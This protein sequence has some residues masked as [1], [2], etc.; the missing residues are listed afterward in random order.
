MKKL[1][2]TRI[3]IFL[4]VVGFLIAGFC[5]QALSSD[6]TVNLRIAST[7]VESTPQ[8]IA[9]QYL[10]KS[11][12]EKSNGRII[13]NLYMNSTLGTEV[14]VLDQV[15]LGVIEGCLAMGISTFSSIDSRM[16]VEELPFLF[17]SESE[18]R[19]AYNGEFGDALKEIISNYGFTTVCFFENG[20]RHITNNIRPIY[21][22]ADLA[23]IKIRV[24]GSAIRLATFKELGASPITMAI[25]EVFTGLQQ[26]TVDGQENPFTSIIG[27]QF[28]EVQKYL[29]LSSHIYN[30]AAI[31][32]NPNVWSAMSESDQKIFTEAALEAQK[33]CYDGCDEY[34]KNSLEKIKDAGMEV[35]QIETEKFIEAV[36]PIWKEYEEKNGSDLINLARKYSL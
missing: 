34:I 15:K 21:T 27:R 32:I 36:S 2:I 16:S 19:N 1:F 6:T 8:G 26:G 24:A 4:L 3:L 7:A 9:L 29:S 20:M 14:E 28:Q 18:A 23:G 35:N 11:V 5:S 25:G 10:K 22:P 30:T 33:V 31:F 13:I 12:M 17:K